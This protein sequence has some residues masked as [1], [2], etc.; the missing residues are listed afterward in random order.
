MQ[1]ALKMICRCSSEKI[2]NMKSKGK[3]GKESK[4]AASLSFGS[5]SAPSTML[6][7][8]VSILPSIHLQPTETLVQKSNQLS[9]DPSDVQ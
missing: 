6:G 8:S 3:V 5:A 1:P 2:K 4:A 7:A 9:I